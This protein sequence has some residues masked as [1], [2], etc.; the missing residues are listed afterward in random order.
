M[1]GSKK[2]GFSETTEK[3][4]CRSQETSSDR[5]HIIECMFYTCLCVNLLYW[6]KKQ[7]PCFAL[8]RKQ[9]E[10]SAEIILQ[11]IC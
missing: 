11:M 5:L 2:P 9:L 1:G 7:T 10:L 8:K 3:E 4:Q 6:I